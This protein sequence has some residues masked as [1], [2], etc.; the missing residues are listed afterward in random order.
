MRILGISGSQRHEYV[1]GTRA[2][3]AAVLENTELDYE[4]VSLRGQN[5]SGC[6]ACLRCT[7][8]NVC[9]VE[10][11]MTSL[12]E[13]VAGAEA[14]VVGAPNHFSGCNAQTRAF[15]ERWFQFR[16]REGDLLWGK[17]GVAVGVGGLD[18]GPPAR[19]IEGFFLF[20]LIEPVA[21]LTATGAAP[22][23]FCGFGETCGIG[24]P[25]MRHGDDVKIG[26]EIIPKVSE[27]PET[28]RAAAQAGKRLGQCLRD[29]WNR[30]E[31]ALRAQDR[32]MDWMA[33]K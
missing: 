21:S 10:D 22:C 32:L 16:H 7:G 33:G 14:Y 1:S 19:D 26:A 20:N 9:K 28:M 11:D 6:T 25:R 29:G 3:V 4:L 18:G 24:I 30:K 2:L 8:D 23:Y 12:R 27:Q 13:A 15:L 5:I 31:A 17:P